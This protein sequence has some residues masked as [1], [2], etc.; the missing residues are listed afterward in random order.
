MSCHAAGGGAPQF[1]FGGTVYDGSG[2][3]LSGAEVRFIDSAGN[4]T[5]V[6]S[7]PAGTFYSAGSVFAG[8]AHVGIRN[9]TISADMFTALQSSSQA[10][11]STGGAC[12]ACHCTGSG[13]TQ[14]GIHLP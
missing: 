10:P 1:T 3:P 2:N 6:Y 7:G 13:C 14:A 12:G 5:V 8:P 4:P 11:A 9:A